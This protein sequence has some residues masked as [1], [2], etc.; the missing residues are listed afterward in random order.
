MP[1]TNRTPMSVLQDVCDAL[2]HFAMQAGF[3]KGDRFPI[4]EIATSFYKALPL[5]FEAF[6]LLLKFWQ[7]LREFLYERS[8]VHAKGYLTFAKY[9]SPG[10][11]VVT[12]NWDTCLEMALYRQG[13]PYSLSFELPIKDNQIRILKPHG[14][15]DFMIGEGYGPVRP[16]IDFIEMVHPAMP[17]LMTIE[18]FKQ[19]QLYRV[20]SYDLNLT[21]EVTWKEGEV[22]ISWQ[23]EPEE[24]KIKTTSSNSNDDDFGYSTDLGPLH[25]HRFLLEA[26]PFLLTPGTPASIYEWSYASIRKAL[27]SVASEIE[28]VYV[29]GYSFP[30]YDQGVIDTLRQ[31]LDRIGRVPVMI[32]NPS[33][34]DLPANTLDRIFKKYDLHDSGFLEFDWE[35]RLS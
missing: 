31:V 29:C 5:G 22:S 20:L 7:A 34:G 4:D 32:V 8:T 21:L 6:D 9:L 15:I 14:S 10:D 28:S 18:G 17:R 3:R 25:L 13:K 26:F 30:P 11:V 12:F 33:P 1:V 23:D 27:F 19:P 35:S 24:S 16:A 2:I